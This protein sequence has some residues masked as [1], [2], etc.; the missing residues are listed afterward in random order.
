[1]SLRMEFRPA[2]L[3]PAEQPNITTLCTAAWKKYSDL[4]SSTEA[5]VYS[6]SG[7]WWHFNDN[8]TKDHITVRY[9][10]RIGG[11][12]VHIYRDGS[13]NLNPQK[14]TRSRTARAADEEGY[15]TV[16]EISGEEFE[17]EGE[18]TGN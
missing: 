17:E 13:V 4:K 3:L 2:T 7:R 5:I 10:R 16:S 6:S 12:R 14:S 11:N 9:N 1:M 15:D 8:D 18:P